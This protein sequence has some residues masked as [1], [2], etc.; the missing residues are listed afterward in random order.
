M[1]VLRLPWLELCVLIPLV[2]AIVVAP[3]RDS[4]FARRTCLVFA[5]LTAL[6][7]VGA[8]QDFGLL[9][10]SQAVSGR[11]LTASILGREL[12]VID[13]LSSPL[14]P[15]AA[16]LH[17]LTIAVTSRTKIR[18]FSFA[19]ALVSD[20]LLIGTFSCQEPW[21]VIGFLAVGTSIPYLELVS[22][23]KPTRGYLIQMALF[24]GLMAAGWIVVEREVAASGTAFWGML[25]VIV[26]MG[27]RCGLFPFHGWM[28]GLFEH[29]TFGLALLSVTPMVG[30]YGIVRL[31]VPMASNGMLWDLGSWALMTAFYASGMSLV[32]NDIRR[33]YCYLFLTHSSLVLV[34]LGTMTS[35]GTTGAL[36]IW[37]SV[38]LAMT[39]LGLTLRALEA[40]RGRLNLTEYQGLY[41]HTPNLAM[42]FGLTGLAA[43]GFPGT[44][45]F[46]G[47][48][49]LVDS[50]VMASPLMGFAVVII[51]ALN[52]IAIVQAFFRL[53]TGCRYN[54]SVSLKIRVRERY[55]VLALAALILI[56]GL[57]P[58]RR[59]TSR[60]EAALQL[61]QSHS[62]HQVTSA[63]P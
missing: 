48:E 32:Q 25:L 56:G 23:G 61:L 19:G 51:G 36:C 21:H 60:H 30:V 16:L 39:G 62:D 4:D 3:L 42:C 50:V 46:V 45:G 63:T 37:L 27:I 18:R 52:G 8:W 7:A 40:R 35:I 20:A 31:I 55:G 54:S 28:C 10:A 29:A 12:F 14:I 1:T 59:V 38:S 17:L 2:G 33:F 34:G 47:M 15:L 41:E 44:F 13:H 6:F 9:Q 57:V 43:V 58:Q 26:A 22:R 5:G 11:H 24:V 53:F 49:I